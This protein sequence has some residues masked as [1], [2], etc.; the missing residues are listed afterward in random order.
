MDL[1]LV[2]TKLEQ[3]HHHWLM[4]AGWAYQGFEMFGRSASSVIGTCIASVGPIA[5][6]MKKKSKKSFF[7]NDFSMRIQILFVF[8]RNSSWVFYIVSIQSSSRKGKKKRLLHNIKQLVKQYA[9]WT[10][11][12]IFSHILIYL[13]FNEW[14]VF[15]KRG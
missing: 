8:W 15:V 6:K 3:F 9:G 5:L 12:L 13:N 10:T 4:G 2:S 1:G 7:E 11:A 14:P